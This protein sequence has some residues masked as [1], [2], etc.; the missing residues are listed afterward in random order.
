MLSIALL[1]LVLLQKPSVP[2]PA[3]AK[4]TELNR[5]LDTGAAAWMHNDRQAA[6]KIYER[7]EKFARANNLP[8]GIA[9]ALVKQGSLYDEIKKYSKALEKYTAALKIQKANGNLKGAAQTLGNMGLSYEDKG[10]LDKAAAC[11]QEALMLHQKLD[12]PEGKAL[13]LLNI[14]DISQRQSNRKTAREMYRKALETA[15]R[16]HQPGLE[17]MILNN[18]G[19][20]FDEMGE[21]LKALDA[22]GKAAT[23]YR[24]ANDTVGEAGTLLNQGVLFDKLGMTEE[25]LENYE[26]SAKHILPDS[27][28][29]RKLKNNLAVLHLNRHD[30]KRA[31]EKLH[32]LLAKALPD[33]PLQMEW[34]DN[35]G[36]A[37]QY[38]G[39][40]QEAAAQ[41]QKALVQA[42][43]HRHSATEANIL[44]N[45][46][47][48]EL[49]QNLIKEASQAFVQARKLYRRQG[50]CEEEA[51]AQFN[52]GIA[53]EA[54]GQN[55]Q[56]EAAYLTAIG[57]IERIR[58]LFGKSSLPSQNLTQKQLTL[59]HRAVWRLIQN[60]KP[61]EA[62][63]LAQ[64]TKA[65]SLLD[66]M[67]TGGD[68]ST[69]FLT[70][71][72]R[73]QQVA[74]Q[75]RAS[76]IQS[77][78]NAEDANAASKPT[79]NLERLRQ[80]LTKTE[81]A[82]ATFTQQM[83]GRH[84]ELARRDM[85]HTLTLDEVPKV[86]DADT[87]L[88]EFVA[89]SDTGDP[90]KS[91]AQMAAFVVTVS[92]GKPKV[93]VVMLSEI[94]SLTEMIAKAHT[95]CT[96]PDS[97][98]LPAMQA[99]TK[100]L[101]S[102][103]EAAVKGKSR[104]IICPDGNLWDVPFQALHNG[105]E[106]LWERFGVTYAYSASAL[107]AAQAIV[108]TRTGALVACANPTF[109]GSRGNGEMKFQPGTRPLSEPTRPQVT[110]IVETAPLATKRDFASGG[111]NSAT[112]PSAALAGA[113]HE[114]EFLAKTEPNAQVFTRS[115]AQETTIKP[116]METARCLHFA[117]HGLVNDTAPMLSC[118]LLADPAK[119]SPD[120]GFLTARE[121]S[122]MRLHAELAVLSA[123]N[124]ARGVTRRGEGIIGLT[125]AIFAAGVPTE[126]ISQW[127]VD[128]SATA[129]LMTQFYTRWHRSGNKSEALRSAALSLLHDNNPKWHHPYY[130]S[131]F[132]L[133]GK[134]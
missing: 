107:H 133:M 79:Q 31:E 99:L 71:E 37:L 52:I 92:A 122:Q 120:D 63:T 116:L 11:H 76:Q 131:P 106:F 91:Q 102:P 35:L 70:K 86:I 65:R 48:A 115:Q 90:V 26:Q 16:V 30:G 8:R 67:E 127:S 23:L 97:D 40:W 128:D 3:P 25:A 53:Q 93:A 46:G 12:D 118:L 109:D 80:Q 72:E 62:F 49:G 100:A 15:H 68:T 110:P 45:L 38:Q 10:E 41:H 39:K 24:Q 89:L 9:I 103:L 95:V 5:M 134:P 77:Q 112:K 2:S 108:P 42:R 28:I 1:T 27:E 111:V 14:A 126:I 17:A 82:F 66:I 47:R 132:I 75:K 51:L 44:N 6:L 32:Q 64:K 85:A 36:I 60:G 105:T 74:L 33:D 123:C 101:F 56:A 20:F 7:V 59:Y 78:M 117:T 114:A 34:L 84:P 119:D 61:A 130:W 125:W 50:R 88:I 19:N 98:Y 18:T 43:K 121:L 94:E 54:Q 22:L 124:T 81:T 73:T 129:E 57:E 13:T 55:T 83:Y 87:A 69:V 104:L 113:Q 58:G 4:V 29:G 21:P 96:R